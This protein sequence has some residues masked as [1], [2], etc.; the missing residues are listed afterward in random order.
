MKKYPIPSFSYIFILLFIPISVF[1]HEKRETFNFGLETKSLVQANY[2]DAKIALEVWVN[3]LGEK[4][5]INVE[6]IYYKDQHNLLKD[7][8]RNKLDIIVKDVVSYLNNNK[9][10]DQNSKFLWTLTPNKER[11]FY[12]YYLIVNKNSNIN[13]FLDLKGKILT[14]K[15][16]DSLA[17]VWFDAFTLKKMSK[18]YFS[19][20]DSQKFVSKQSR[21]VLDVLFEKTDIAIVSNDTWD[22]M[23]T[24]NPSIGN[25]LKI[26]YKSKA[27]FIPILGATKKRDEVKSVKNELMKKFINTA[28]RVESSVSTK[29]I[30]ALI[31]FKNVRILKKNELS[32]LFKFYKEYLKLKKKYL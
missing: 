31:K 21:V 4:E 19:I 16:N 1:S 30:R 29:Q 11:L 28:N 7:F 25:R 23:T 24:L 13:S 8:S 2:A 6:V 27:I 12:Q 20:I 14:L 18:S 9:I 17:R 3:E 10:I 5:D 22:T 26:L 15:D 32:E